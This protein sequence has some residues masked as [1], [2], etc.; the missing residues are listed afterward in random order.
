MQFLAALPERHKAVA[1]LSSGAR[2][3]QNAIV[4]PLSSVD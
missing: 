3:T 4:I 2:L 1:G